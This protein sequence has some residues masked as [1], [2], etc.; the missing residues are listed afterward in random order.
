MLHLGRLATTFANGERGRDTVNEVA[1]AVIRFWSGNGARTSLKPGFGANRMICLAG[2][3]GEYFAAQVGG[4]DRS[5]LKTGQRA[6]HS[7]ARLPTN[8]TLDLGGSGGRTAW[9][10]YSGT[11]GFPFVERSWVRNNLESA[12]RTK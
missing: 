10:G 1:P 9:A 12:G 7:T 2:R 11:A 5:A 8:D 4:G 3:A 6:I